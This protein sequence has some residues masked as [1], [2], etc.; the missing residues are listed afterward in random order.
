MAV[1]T[2]QSRPSGPSS[3]SAAARYYGEESTLIE[4]SPVRHSY[5]EVLLL[6]CAA[7]DGHVSWYLC[8]GASHVLG[9][10]IYCCGLHIA[11]LWQACCVIV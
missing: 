1:G 7:H 10:W 5:L 3:A 9:Y 8:V 4:L 11:Y 2:R 6:S